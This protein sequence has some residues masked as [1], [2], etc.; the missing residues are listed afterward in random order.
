[1]RPNVAFTAPAPGAQVSGTVTVTATASDA[2]GVTRMALRID[3]TTVLDRSAVTSLSHAWNTTPVA[4]GSHELSV[5]AWDAAGNSA[6][7][8]RSVTVR[9][10]VA[11]VVSI[12][13]PVANGHVSGTVT[14]DA[15]ATDAVGVTR[16]VLA[17]DGQTRVTQ[18]GAAP[19]RWTWSTVGLAAG[20][21][22]IAVS[23]YDAAWNTSTRT[24][25]V[26]VDDVLAPTLGITSPAA[27]AQVTGTV[28]VAATAADAVG[29]SR[30]TL[31]IDGTVVADR[32]GVTTLSH[33]WNTGALAE[34]SSHA[35]RFTAWDAAGN[36]TIANRTVTIRDVRGPVVS[37]TAPAAGPLGTPAA[38]VSVSAS[39]GSG[40]NRLVLS[41]DG[42]PVAQ[43]TGAG[44]L[45]WHW[46]ASGLALGS[47]HTLSAVAADLAGNTTTQ[48]LSVTIADAIAPT[49]TLLRPAPGEV[50]SG[51]EMVEVAASD[52]RE[53]ARLTLRVNSTIVRDETSADA[54]VH[55]FDAAARPDGATVYLNVTADDAAGN[56]S[57]AWVAVTVDHD[58]VGGGAPLGIAP[59]SPDDNVDLVP[60]AFADA[61]SQGAEILYWYESWAE[62]AANPNYVDTVL[63]PLVAGG[64]AA[65]NFDLIGATVLSDYP[66][67]YQS[68]AD[69]GFAEAF[70]TFAAAFAARYGLE[71]VFVGNEVNIYLESHPELVDDVALLVR[72]TRE[73]VRA[74]S[75]S[76]RVGVVV[77][78]GYVVDHDQYEMLRTLA[79]EADL[80]GYTAYGYEQNGFSYEFD[81]PANGILALEAAAT[82]YPGKPYAIV[83]TGWNSSTTLGSSEEKQT[84]FVRLLRDHLQ[85]S[86]AEF[87]SLFLYEDGVDCTEIVQGFHLPDLD[88]DPT[89]LQFRLFEDFVC[90]FGLKRSD[91]TPKQAWSALPLP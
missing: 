48:T 12:T 60:A 27:N 5:T 68:P 57:L 52:E 40:V 21:H 67:P 46:D 32:T 78:H 9:D 54:F 71:Y 90:N 82:A 35:L 83:E 30:M 44:T 16:M 26:T 29:V 61:R 4:V 77:S 41:L 49:V 85:T 15:S 23:A 37:F 43:R 31:A 8:T 45:G 11:P 70:S 36:R 28:T 66:A 84:T 13:S 1:V 74:A 3:G 51:L 53:V 2:Y 7:A 73:K 14:I 39:D 18:T 42:A 6:T 63:F 64:P 69:P 79:D 75:P 22:T 56:R 24:I 34:R 17:V 72:R 20:A 38:D 25:S 19:I 76:T 55:L 81:D 62:A 33:A 10:A 59:T 88:P 86:D 91:G 89:S 47:V 87:V 80:V 58:A 50:V 65:V